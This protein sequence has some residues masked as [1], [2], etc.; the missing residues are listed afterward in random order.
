MTTNEIEDYV[1][2][3]KKKSKKEEQEKATISTVVFFI[4]CLPVW[5]FGKYIEGFFKLT[6][7]G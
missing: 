1:E 5:F 6:E 4:V 3:Q 7:N 2:E